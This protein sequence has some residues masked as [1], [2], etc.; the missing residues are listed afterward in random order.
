MH[1]YCGATLDACQSDHLEW[2]RKQAIDDMQ[3]AYINLSRVRAADHLLIVQQ[4]SPELFRQGELPGPAL[5]MGVL[6]GQQTIEQAT[7]AWPLL[8]VAKNMKKHETWPASMKLPCRQCSSNSEGLEERKQLN[9]LSIA[10][11]KDRNNYGE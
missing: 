11:Q 4:Q 10:H 2:S 7:I 8:N 3:R 1:G 9:M 5:V 6:R